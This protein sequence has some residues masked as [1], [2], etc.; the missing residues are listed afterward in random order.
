MGQAGQGKMTTHS[1]KKMDEVALIEFRNRF[2]LPLSDE[3]ATQ[4]AFYKPADDSPEMQYLQARRASLG[5][6]LP[7]RH[8]TAPA[9][10]VPHLNSYAQFALQAEQKEMDKL[11]T[12][13]KE[14]VVLMK[15]VDEV[16]ANTIGTKR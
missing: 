1:Q 15:E 12:F 11:V 10:K 8:T 5:G 13:Y 6:F 9:L 14:E 16:M 3:Q 4:L 2:N 7:Q